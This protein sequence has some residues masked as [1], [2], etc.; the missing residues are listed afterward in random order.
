MSS[1]NAHRSSEAS[2]FSAR[3]H[4]SSIRLD[5]SGQSSSPSICRIARSSDSARFQ[6]FFWQ[7][8]PHMAPSQSSEPTVDS[9]PAL[10]RTTARLHAVGQVL[11]RLQAQQVYHPHPFPIS[12]ANPSQAQ[13]P[14]PVQPDLDSLQPTLSCQVPT[15]GMPGPS[16]VNTPEEAALDRRQD[17]TSSVHSF[18][19]DQYSCPHRHANHGSVSA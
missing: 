2:A 5:D 10:D 15:Q 12:L 3:S 17:T 8:S 16:P 4:S 18:P 6:S 7:H 1:Y 14:P 9:I 19:A 11:A 13:Y